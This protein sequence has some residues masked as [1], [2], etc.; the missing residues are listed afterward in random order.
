MG[1]SSQALGFLLTA[2]LWGG[3]NPFVKRGTRGLDAYQ[4]SIAGRPWPVRA[5]LEAWWLVTR[6]QFV[7]PSLVNLLGTIS[8]YRTL[9]DAADLTLAVPIANTLTFA[10]T[11]LAGY[12]LGEDVGDPQT[13]AGFALVLAGG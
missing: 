5:L 1:A 11:F 6:W 9:A 13:W 7:V 10:F 4:A 12:L 2:A 3:T 8:F